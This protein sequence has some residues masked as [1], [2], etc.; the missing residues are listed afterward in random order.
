MKRNSYFHL[1]N[2][3]DVADGFNDHLLISGH[4]GENLSEDAEYNLTVAD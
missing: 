1:D 4:H 2:F 3:N